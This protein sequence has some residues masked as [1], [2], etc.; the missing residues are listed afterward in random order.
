MQDLEIIDFSG[1][2]NNEIKAHLIKEN[3]SVDLSNADVSSG[4]LVPFSGKVNSTD[5]EIPELTYQNGDRSIIRFGKEHYWTNNTEGTIESTLG[6][7][8]ITPP[9]S[10]IKL[11]RG[12]IGNRF[13]GTRSYLIRYLSD[14]G[15]RSAPF[16]PE[17]AFFYTNDINADQ[18]ERTPIQGEYPA[19]SQFYYVSYHHGT[20]LYGYNTGARVNHI[21]HSWELSSGITSPAVMSE[22]HQ[23]GHNELWVN[24]DNSVDTLA[25][26]DSIIIGN[27]PSPNEQEASLIEIYRTIENGTNFYLLDTLSTT[28][29]EYIDTL[30][31]SQIQNRE[32][33]LDFLGFPPVYL[34]EGGQF[35]RK[36]GKF[37][38]ELDEVYNIAYEDRLF[39]TAQSDPHSVNPA[40]GTRFNGNITGIAEIDD[41]LIVFIENKKP[42][43]KRGSKAAGNLSKRPIPSTQG[44]PNWRTITYA[45]NTPLWQS[46][47]GICGIIRQPLG[48]GW[49]IK[50]LTKRRYVFDSIGNWAIAHKDIYYL[51]YDDHCVCFDLARSII[52]RRDITADYGFS[53][54][55][56]LY[57]VEGGKFYTLDSGDA[58]K[59]KYTSP[60][61]AFSSLSMAKE[62]GNFHVD[63]DGDVDYSIWY[64]D[65]LKLGNKTMPLRNKVRSVKMPPGTPYRI[66]LQLESNSVIRGYKVEWDNAS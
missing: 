40:H 24:I 44:C 32:Q 27:I 41:S 6:Y 51:F 42:W 9:S 58:Q 19:W 37:I 1:G 39:E 49:N 7:V 46:Y 60:D 50:V 35:V 30:S 59:I 18:T 20:Y 3:E 66:K 12:P 29:G 23:P 13:N 15:F 16:L 25:G 57:L 63:S 2:I 8:G 38:T 36:G 34:L 11:S 48:Q 33:L 14:D 53:T 10:I 62:F 43:L 54:N 26:S 64:D 61:L 28:T 45:N 5:P 56:I 21:G 47:D 4:S 22:S 55:N 65:K 31:D 52:Y 17:N